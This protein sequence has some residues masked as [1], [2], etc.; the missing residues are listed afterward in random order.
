[1]PLQRVARLAEPAWQT[2]GRRAPALLG[3]QVVG[4]GR[5]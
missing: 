2:L 3:Y 5:R 1:V 4:I